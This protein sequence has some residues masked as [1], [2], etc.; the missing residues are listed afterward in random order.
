MNTG[1]GTLTIDWAKNGWVVSHRTK[2]G[3]D[4]FSQL[5]RMEKPQV[6]IC[7]TSR[8]VLDE[9]MKALGCAGQSG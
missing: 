5:P 4:S 3:V 9:V 8:G 7:N 1:L 2:W 6:V